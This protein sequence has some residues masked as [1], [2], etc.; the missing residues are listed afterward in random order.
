M[1]PKL[2]LKIR[3]SSTHASF[4]FTWW[5]KTILI[6]SFIGLIWLLSCRYLA[7][8]LER[9]IAKGL[10]GKPTMTKEDLLNSVNNGDLIFLAGET[11]GERTIR[12]FHNSYYSHMFL[13]FRDSPPDGVPDTPE[14]T[15]FVWEADVGQGYK[16]GPRI[17]RLSEKLD[18]WKGM[19]IGMFKRYIPPDAFGAD[20]PTTKDI[21]DIA[22]S[23]LSE[24]MDM[25][26]VMASW[27]FS[28]W[29][30]GF[31]FKLFKN[32]KKVFC[33]ELVVDTLQKLG[34]MSKERHPSWYSPEDFVRGKVPIVK[35]TFSS[36]SIYFTL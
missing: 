22:Q 30:D 14:N 35:G 13:V 7:P 25:D 19:K 32:Q 4:Q 24:N 9:S 10:I 5:E 16:D 27:F 36:L 26:M 15:V 33:S 23:Y 3:I 20:R 29:P 6:L 18:R 31:L 21:L 17:M 34:I 1:S 28:R 12:F 8:S 11:Q 2:G